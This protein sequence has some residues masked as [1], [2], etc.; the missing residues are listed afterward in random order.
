MKFR[1][2][3]SFFRS[4]ATQHHQVVLGGGKPK[5]RH[6]HAELAGVLGTHLSQDLGHAVGQLAG[7]H[8]QAPVFVLFLF[9]SRVEVQQ[10]ITQVLLG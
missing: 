9:T 2:V 3:L 6:T 5:A 8:G 1:L 10:G 4:R 7:Q